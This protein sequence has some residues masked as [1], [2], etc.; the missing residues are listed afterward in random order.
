MI[1]I[2]SFPT[3][4]ALAGWLHNARIRYGRRNFAEWLSG[5]MHHREFVVNDRVYLYRDCINLLRM[6]DM[7][8][9]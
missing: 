3:V 4:A 2:Q 9:A 7:Q 1:V 8:N 5:Y 6:E